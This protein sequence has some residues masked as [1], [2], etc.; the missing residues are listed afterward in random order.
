MSKV[1]KRSYP[2][3][4][5]PLLLLESLSL[6]GQGIDSTTT[7]STIP[8]LQ[9]AI[10]KVLLET[11]TPAVGLVMME[12]DSVIWMAGLG[13]ANLEEAT[14]ATEHTL[15]RIGSVSKMFVS[16]AVLKLQEEGLLSLDDQVRELVPEI[17][18]HNPWEDTAP[19][20]VS[21]LLEHTTGWD[22]LHM[23]EYAL[24][25]PDITLKEA[26]DFHPHSR[27]SRWM[28][29]TRMSYSNSGAS[30]AAYIVEK[31]TGK[32]FEDYIQDQFFDPM[33]MEAMTFF[34]SKKYQELGAVLYHD[35]KPQN[36]WHV[37][38]RPSGSINASPKDM[39]KMLRFFINRGRVDSLT[40]I[41]ETSLKRMETPTTSS[42]AKGGLEYGYGLANYSTPHKAFVYQS[43][44]GGVVGGQADISYLPG[45]GVGY[46]VMINSGNGH[47]LQQISQLI[48]DFQTADL[49]AEPLESIESAVVANPDIAGYYVPINPRLQRN[50]FIERIMHV[51]NIQVQRNGHL[52][53]RNFL[54]G[55][56][57]QYVP[58]TKSTFTSPATGRIGLVHV[59]DPLAGAV[60]HEGTLVLEPISPI[61]AYGQFGFGLIWVV[62][63]AVSLFIGS[64]YFIAHM[65]GRKFGTS[66]IDMGLFPY[67][68]SVCLVTIIVAGFFLS[69]NTLQLLGTVNPISVWIMFATLG[70]SFASVWS[71]INL[72]RK[73]HVAVSPTIYWHL[74]I[75]SGLH[76]SVAIYLFSHGIIGLRTWG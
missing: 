63:T 48:R 46:V 19:I 67:L 16:L 43:H 32:N 55:V 21:H 8:Q 69:S 72:I 58:H 44:F 68:A 28:P 13:M 65:R 34:K 7:R 64:Y 29:G 66:R 33:G 61:L 27:T 73:R 70:F 51:R 3:F 60:V 40:L 11:K 22:D 52:V 50:Y 39:S 1:H 41:S 56:G 25:D 6:F 26:L 71:L 59:S 37:A 15:F 62:Y 54:G 4:F 35:E 17:E 23:S 20:V 12:G 14:K 76:T 2:L 45:Y 47:A 74:L 57:Q 36:Y 38:V 9:T 31:I 75:L 49:V 53:T 10:E 30:V 5:V 24:N 42:G 18:F